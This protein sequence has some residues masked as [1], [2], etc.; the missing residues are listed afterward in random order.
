MKDE[1]RHHGAVNESSLEQQFHKLDM[2]TFLVGKSG[3][4]LLVLMGLTYN[5]QAG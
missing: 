3:A 1:K 2:I 5:R 4:I